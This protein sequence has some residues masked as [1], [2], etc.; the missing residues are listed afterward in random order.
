[1]CQMVLM[2]VYDV[3][4]RVNSTESGEAKAVVWGEKEGT[5]GKSY[6]IIFTN[7]VKEL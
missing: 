7:S 2:I 4:V 5:E 3:T 1:M 6:V